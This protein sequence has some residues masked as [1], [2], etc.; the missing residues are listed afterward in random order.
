VKQMGAIGRLGRYLEVIDKLPGDQVT[1]SSQDLAGLVKVTPS[2]VRQDFFTYLDKKGKSRVGYDVK[3]LRETLLTR[4]G[5]ASTMK[6]IV[7]GG[8]K[9]GRALVGYKEFRM[10]NIAFAAFFDNDERKVGKT[11]DDVPV[12]H[13]SELKAYLVKHPDIRMAI[14]AVPGEV[15]QDVA[16]Y[17]VKC[18]IEALWNFTPVLL[19]V[20]D[21]V[22]VQNEYIGESLYNL[23][24]EINLRKG[25]RKGGNKMELMICVGSSCHLRGS[26]EVVKRFQVLIEKEKVNKQVILKGSFCMGQCSETG[27]TVQFGSNFYKTR[28]EDAETLFYDTLLPV[29]KAGQC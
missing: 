28:P 10:I 20:R 19:N 7:I 21:D 8:G 2:T 26:E 15:A 5:L 23:I 17:T 18:G 4:L 27:V 1:I 29:L 13:I 3:Q 11:Q 22:V 14:L 25:S 16:S 6:V 24:Y 12:Y 9:L